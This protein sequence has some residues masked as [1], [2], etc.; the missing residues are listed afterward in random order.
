[1]QPAQLLAFSQTLHNLAD[2]F[3]RQADDFHLAMWDARKYRNEEMA[4]QF[5]RLRDEAFAKKCAVR[6]F[7]DAGTPLPESLSA[8]IDSLR[9]D[10][11]PLNM[12]VRPAFSSLSMAVHQ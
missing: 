2:S 11:P 7:L 1:M 10:F 3:M 9:P 5:A 8:E 12:Q 4:E 6:S